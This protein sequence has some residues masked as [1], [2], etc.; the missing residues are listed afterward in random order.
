[1]T[2]HLN[3]LGINLDVL[4]EIIDIS[5]NAL[6]EMYPE[7]NASKEVIKNVIIEEKNKFM[8]TLQNGEREFSDYLRIKFGFDNEVFYKEVEVTDV[9]ILKPYYDEYS[10]ANDW[11]ICVLDEK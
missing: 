4:S 6:N 10:Q 5:I 1:M 9:Y 8:K 7:L 3:K 11:A 2:R